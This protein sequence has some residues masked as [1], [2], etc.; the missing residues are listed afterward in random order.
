MSSGER[1]VQELINESLQLSVIKKTIY[2]ISIRVLSKEKTTVL[3]PVLIDAIN[4]VPLKE[5]RNILR[6]TNN[7][8]EYAKSLEVVVKTVIRRYILRTRS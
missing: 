1:D 3:V 6:E 8:D 2:D 5:L 7:R 4:G